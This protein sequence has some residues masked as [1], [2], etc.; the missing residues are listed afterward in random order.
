MGKY[1]SD[2]GKPEKSHGLFLLNQ[3]KME[4]IICKKKC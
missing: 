3:M 1:K 4:K 2:H